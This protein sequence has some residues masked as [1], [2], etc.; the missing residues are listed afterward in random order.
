MSD[1]KKKGG[2][3]SAQM[4]LLTTDKPGF[5]SKKFGFRVLASFGG[6]GA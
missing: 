4:V 6:R 3:N 2:G 1:I 5:Y